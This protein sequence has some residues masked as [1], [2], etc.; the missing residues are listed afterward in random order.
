MPEKILWMSRIIVSN[1]RVSELLCQKKLRKNWEWKME[2]TY[3]QYLSIK[4]DVNNRGWCIG[5]N[6]TGGWKEAKIGAVNL[7]IVE[8]S[9]SYKMS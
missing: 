7:L 4:M 6:K 3:F 8:I 1:G 2:I 5:D 9:L